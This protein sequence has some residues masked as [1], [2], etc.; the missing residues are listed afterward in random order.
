MFSKLETCAG[1]RTNLVAAVI[2]VFKQV[3]YEFEHLRWAY[4]MH[5]PETGHG[6]RNDSLQV[7]SVM[8]IEAL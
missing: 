3:Q 2:A 7:V 8:I 5:I 6:Q 4:A 1:G